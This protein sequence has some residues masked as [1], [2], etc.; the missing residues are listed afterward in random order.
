L[1]S[2]PSIRPS[3]EAVEGAITVID[4]STDHATLRIEA[5]APVILLVTDAYA[6]GWRAW[7]VGESP[8]ESY[9]V[10][11]ANLALRAIPLEAGTHEI[12]ME[13][14]PD[15]FVKGRIATLIAGA[16]FLV[17]IA[18]SIM[19]AYAARRSDRANRET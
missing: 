17:L 6:E 4:E 19:R 14:L 11:P 16:V 18:A 3:G 15:A 5:P 10:M 2:E 7:A 13:Y 1:E 12:R 8:Q 9:T